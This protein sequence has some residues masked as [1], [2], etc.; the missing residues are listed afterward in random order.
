MSI[1]KTLKLTAELKAV[2]HGDKSTRRK[3]SQV[4]FAAARPRGGGW[5]NL[6]IGAANGNGRLRRKQTLTAVAATGSNVPDPVP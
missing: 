2:V 5:D 3:R 1:L 6:L 4:H